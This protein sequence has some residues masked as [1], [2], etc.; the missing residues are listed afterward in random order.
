MEEVTWRAVTACR[1]VRFTYASRESAAMRTRIDADTAAFNSGRLDRTRL[2]V[3]LDGKVPA[4]LANVA[5]RLDG[6]AIIPPAEPAR[7]G[8]IR[9]L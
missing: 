5:R 2:Y 7:C 1:P 9:L 3:L 8:K 6:V 4:K